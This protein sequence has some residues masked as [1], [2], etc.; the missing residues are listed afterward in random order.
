LLG[1][2]ERRVERQERHGQGVDALVQILDRVRLRGTGVV[3][4]EDVADG[5][6]EAERQT[7]V[8]QFREVRRRFVDRP[9]LGDVV[10][11]ALD[12]QCLGAGDGF[13]EAARD[14]VGALAVDAVIREGELGVCEVRP[15]LPLPFGVAGLAT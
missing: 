5:D 11:P 10:D 14:L 13:V 2:F 4:R 12:D 1:V 7:A 9:A 8:D 15:V 3:P 6:A